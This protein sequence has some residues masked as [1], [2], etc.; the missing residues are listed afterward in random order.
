MFKTF[1]KVFDPLPIDW[2]L[3]HRSENGLP[4]E[5]CEFRQCGDQLWHARGDALTSGESHLVRFPTPDEARLEMLR[6]V[7]NRKEGGFSEAASAIQARGEFDFEALKQAVKLAA[8]QS[9]ELVREKHPTG[10]YGFGLTTD[11]VPMTLYAMA[12]TVAA[13]RAHTDDDYRNEAE[14]NLQA[15]S[16]EEGANH[17][18]VVHKLLLKQSRSDIPFEREMEPETFANRA[19]D[20]FVSALE[21]LRAEGTFEG[22]SD[23]P[24]VLMVQP[25]DFIPIDGMIERLNA[26]TRLIERYYAHN[27]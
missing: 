16:I 10:L 11:G 18:D 8:R 25:S 21:E 15:W 17:F 6:L 5:F 7:S 20:T 23:E 14:W 27:H 13:I 3:L 2:R 19:F 26:D 12:Q 24:L 1:L 22:V 4:V 9:F